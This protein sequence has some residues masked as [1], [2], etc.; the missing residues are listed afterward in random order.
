MLRPICG[1]ASASRTAV[2]K[3]SSPIRDAKSIIEFGMS[4]VLSKQKCFIFADIVHPEGFRFVQH[5]SGM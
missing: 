5:D 4:N 2:V 1:E 3:F